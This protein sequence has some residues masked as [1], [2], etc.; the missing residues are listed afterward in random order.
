MKTKRL[1]LNSRRFISPIKFIHLAGFMLWVIFYTSSAWAQTPDK[2]NNEKSLALKYGKQIYRNGILPSGNP[3][4]ATVQGDVEL[5]GDLVTCKGCHRRS[6]LGSSESDKRVLPITKSALYD[7]IEF[8]R[9]KEAHLQRKDTNPRPKYNDKTL[10]AAIRDGIDPNGRMLD[11]LMPHFALNDKE[12]DYLV[13]YIKSLSSELS[14]GISDTSIK[15]STIITE[16]AD[17]AKANIMLEVL[18]KFFEVKNANT[19]NETGRAKH[20]PWHKQPEYT[21]YRKWELIEWRLKGEPNTWQAQLKQLYDDNPIFAVISGMSTKS[22][23]PIHEFCVDTELPCL[24]PNTDLP[25]ISD[26]DFYPV[27]FTKGLTLQA[28]VLAKYLAKTTPQKNILLQIYQD[29]TW[30]KTPAAIIK[31][32]KKLNNAYTVQSVSFSA[33]VTANDINTLIKKHNPTHVILWLKDKSINQLIPALDHHSH[34]KQLFLPVSILGNN[35]TLEN[36]NMSKQLKFIYTYEIPSNNYLIRTLA[37]IKAKK[38]DPTDT[39][40]LANTYFAAKI[41][42]DSITHARTSLYRDFVLERI[43]HATDNMLTTSV[44]PHV[45]LAPSQRFVSKGGYI[46]QYDKTQKLQAISDWLVP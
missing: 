17:P 43:E 21:G 32:S 23:Q 33:P 40:I 39:F 12:L 29:N 46:A 34:V 13:T 19:R 1:F 9:S 35:Y 4:T 20:S 31:S 16:D 14:P 42:I 27:Y 8:G 11:P 24:F 18:H 6:G 37:W 30:G 25:K 5:S 10:K 22:W 15:F 28:E 3:L 36:S 38:I 41:A 44:F 26:T 45:S 2:T 7:R